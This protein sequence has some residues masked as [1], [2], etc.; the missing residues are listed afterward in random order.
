M[1]RWI[2]TTCKLHSALDFERSRNLTQGSNILPGKQIF[3]NHLPAAFRWRWSFFVSSAKFQPI[4]PKC[5]PFSSSNFKSIFYRKLLPTMG[6]H[7]HALWGL[8]VAINSTYLS[9]VLCT[10]SCLQRIVL[11]RLSLRKR[12]TCRLFLLRMVQKSV[13]NLHQFFCQCS[14]H[15]DEFQSS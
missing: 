9:Q 4:T 5:W 14:T 6:V 13:I 15:S 12:T 10:T 2:I 3:M 8:R 11:R 1:K 7:N